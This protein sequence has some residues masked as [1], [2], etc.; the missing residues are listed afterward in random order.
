MRAERRVDVARLGRLD[1]EERFAVH[2]RRRWRG[3]RR[4]IDGRHLVDA[5]RHDHGRNRLLLAHKVVVD[6]H[7]APRE[8]NDLELVHVAGEVAERESAE[9]D[10]LRHLHADG[11]R[12]LLVLDAVDVDARAGRASVVDERQMPQT[13]LRPVDRHRMQVMAKRPR[14]GAVSAVR[15]EISANNAAR[16]KTIA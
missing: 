6:V 9:R 16:A 8:R 4:R 11:A 3:R 13:G 7:R 14:H 2:R 5:G 1:H 10:E 12:A 15:A